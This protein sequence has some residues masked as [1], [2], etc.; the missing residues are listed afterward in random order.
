MNPDI[1]EAIA[2]ST[3]TPCAKFS[4]RQRDVCAAE[5]LACDAWIYYI[6]SGAV[7]HPMMVIPRRRTRTKQPYMGAEIVAT[8]EKFESAEAL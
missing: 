4:C 6:E 2:L 7:K 1:L 5:K 8:R 3:D